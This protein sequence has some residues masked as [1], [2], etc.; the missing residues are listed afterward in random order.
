M[1][2][3]MTSKKNVIRWSGLF[4]C[5]FLPLAFAAQP[6]TAPLRTGPA[7]FGDWS[8]DAPG[9]VRHITVADLPKPFASRSADNGPRLVARPAGAMPIAPPGFI[10]QL[11]ADNLRNPRKII[12]APN[13]DVFIVESAA[14]RITAI[15]LAANG[16][17]AERQV[18]ADKLNQ[19]FGIAFYPPGQH[20]EFVY[21]ANT[22]SVVRFAYQSGDLQARG[23]AQTIVPDLSAGGRLRG[24]GHWTRDVVFSPDGGRMFVSVG[25]RSNN[26]DNDAEF[27]RAN[28]LSY[29]PDGSDFSIYA[30]G[31]RNAVGLAI[32]PV[33][34][35]LW[36][37]VNERDGLGDNLP[38]DYITHVEK[39]GFY[40]WPWFYIGGHYD[41][42]HQGKHAELRDKV[43]VPDVLLQAHSASLCMTFYTGK[44]FGEEYQNDAFAALH[45]SWNRAKRTGYK[46][47][48]VPMRQGRATG[49]YE[50]FLTG[51]TTPTG[52]VWGRPVGVAVAKDGS[53]LVSDDAANALWR[54]SR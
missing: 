13:G 25:S 38:P 31:L 52:D 51:F 43:I 10:V 7:A 27:H 30:S 4:L 33:T 9:V 19:P 32:N 12:T 1:R 16:T 26:D 34:G 5:L 15:R 49:E 28:I 42:K 29:R 24:G 48:R 44:M 41:P 6:A 54:I 14:G 36:A 35:Q 2:M 53:L 20:P 23:E 17:I 37:S 45:G 3:S 21:V 47:I 39:G 11:L 8:T 18:Y 22:G 50:D 40:G 46:V